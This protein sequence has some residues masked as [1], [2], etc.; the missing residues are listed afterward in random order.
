[1]AEPETTDLKASEPVESIEVEPAANDESMADAN[2][3]STVEIKG[4]DAPG[5]KSDEDAEAE[6]DAPAEGGDGRPVSREQYKAFKSIT[7]ALTDYRIKVKDEYVYS[8]CGD[9]VKPC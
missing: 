8:A 7:D 2:D 5:D 1:M 9:H 6:E 3:E 4:D